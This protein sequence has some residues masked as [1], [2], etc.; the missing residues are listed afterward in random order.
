MAMKFHENWDNCSTI[1]V[2]KNASKTGRVLLGHNEDDMN[3]V[4]QTH[5]VPRMEHKEGEVLT[6]DD[7]DAVVPQVPVTWGYMWSELRCPGGEP[8]AD[9]FVSL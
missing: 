4:V 1:I 7:G 2:G 9:G 5:M 8:F 3:C 6:F